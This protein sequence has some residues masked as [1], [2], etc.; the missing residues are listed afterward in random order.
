[1]GRGASPLPFSSPSVAVR[2]VDCG[3]GNAVVGNTTRPIPAPEES[4]RVRGVAL[5]AGVRAGAYALED[6][7]SVL[8]TRSISGQCLVEGYGV[9]A[10]P[11]TK[12]RPS[13]DSFFK[14]VKPTFGRG[15]WGP[16]CF[17]S[18]EFEPFVKYGPVAMFC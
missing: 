9:T 6:V 10:P 4:E 15:P 11:S 12:L 18:S 8:A 17:R 1:M 14:F 3:V 7:D 5:R 13:T 16:T 2:L